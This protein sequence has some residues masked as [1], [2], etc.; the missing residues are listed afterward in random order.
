MKGALDK[1]SKEYEIV[2][3]SP[4]ECDWSEETIA[5]WVQYCKTNNVPAVVGF[6]QKDSWHHPLINMG[7]GNITL[8]PLR[9]LRGGARSHAVC[10]QRACAV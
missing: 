5:Y 10:T 1:L 6:A 9:V 4:A 3:I 8:N 2:P 7:L